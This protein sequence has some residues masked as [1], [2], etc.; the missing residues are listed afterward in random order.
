MSFNQIYN[1]LLA[2]IK[3]DDLRGIL[4]AIIDC[5]FFAQ[6]VML[7]RHLSAELHP[8]MVVFL[9]LS[10]GMLVLLPWAI[11]H[12]VANITLKRTDLFLGRA[13][14]GVASMAMYTIAIANLPS[15][16]ITAIS[17]TV[18]I[19][20]TFLAVF[21]FKEKLSIH[22]I[23]ALLIGFLGVSVIVFGN[24]GKINSYTGIVIFS[25]I[26]W[27]FTNIIMKKLAI[28]Y[29]SYDIRMSVFLMFIFMIPFAFILALPVWS[30]ITL[31]Q[32]LLALLQGLCQVIS[33]LCISK[34][35]RTTEMKIL[36][37]FDFFRLVFV[38]IFA[39]F[40]FNEIITLRTFLGAVIIICGAIYVVFNISRKNS[41]LPL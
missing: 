8:Y 18:P 9:R 41:K 6:V 12:G 36:M 34:A 31:M 28:T 16:Q 14:F 32:F 23:I 1:K 37:P 20:T 27:A 30:G 19:I 24:V 29:Y 10:C 40:W 2:K 21:F 15:T 39:Y 35:Y 4:L 25:A 5:F 3:S 17:F 26:L 38:S 33:Q 11:K 22:L 7:T 13:V